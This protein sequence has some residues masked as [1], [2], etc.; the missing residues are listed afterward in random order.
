MSMTCD[1]ECLACSGRCDGQHDGST[2]MHSRTFHKVQYGTTYTI[3]V[4][5]TWTGVEGAQ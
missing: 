1:V 3:T 5:H 4:I 2:H